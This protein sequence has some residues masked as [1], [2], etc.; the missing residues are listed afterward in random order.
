MSRE[1]AVAAATHNVEQMRGESDK[2]LRQTVTA[3]EAL[4][5]ALQ[6][7][8]LSDGMLAQIYADADRI[9]S[10]SGMFGL[11]S[12][13]SAAR[14][15]CN[16]LAALTTAKTRDTSGIAVHVS[17]LRLMTPGAAPMTPHGEAFMLEELAKLVRHYAPAA[18]RAAD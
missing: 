18:G 17:A 14:S 15:L 10:L 6:G 12:L 9:V 4:V 3:M 7:E 8:A 2:V 5:A 13:N 16:L 11:A 1:D